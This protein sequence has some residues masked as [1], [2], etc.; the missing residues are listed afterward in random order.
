[1]PQI[2]CCFLAE[3]TLNNEWKTITVRKP[4]LIERYNNLMN[5]ADKSDQILAKYNLLRKC[6]RWWK[7]IFFHLIDI[8][9]VN[10]FILSKSFSEQNP[11]NEQL[12]C[13][14]ED[15]FLE[16]RKELIRNLIDLDECA[17]LPLFRL[18]PSPQNKSEF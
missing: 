14:K 15:S 8:T 3:V 2:S 6:V 17:D 5:G 12:Q 18:R 11:D 16:F 9:T 10:S 7:T 1:M 4:Y 13:K